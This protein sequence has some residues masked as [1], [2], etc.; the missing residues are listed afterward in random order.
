M[1]TVLYRCVCGETIS[2]DT[3]E[4]GGCPECGR[5]FAADVVK[6]ALART[7]T[8]TYTR[9]TRDCVSSPASGEKPENSRPHPLAFIE[10]GGA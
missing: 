9:D 8:G 4:G 1:G 7:A 2:L 10:L 3:T 5:H 6:D